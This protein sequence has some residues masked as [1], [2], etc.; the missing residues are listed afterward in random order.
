MK[1]NSPFKRPP[2]PTRPWWGLPFLS[3]MKRDMLGFLQQAHTEYGD[4][5]Y[6]RIAWECNYDFFHPELAREVLVDKASSFIRWERATAIFAQVHGQSVLVTEGDVWQR[7][8]R[9]LQPG[10]GPKR[11]AGYARLMVEASTKAL[12]TLPKEAVQTVDFEHQMTILTMEVIMQTLFSSDAKADALTAEKAVRTIA[13]VGIEEMFVP[14]SLPDWL[15]Q[16]AEFRWAKR[17]L[18]AL[19]WRHIHER[20]AQLQAGAPAKDDLL[21]MLMALR[22]DEANTTGLS[23]TEIRDQCM[24]IF[25]AGHETT[26][27]ALTWWGWTMASNP[28]CAVLATEEVDRVLA[29]RPPV[30]EDVAALAYLGQTLRETMRLHPSVPLLFTRR[31]TEDVQIGPWRVPKGAMVRVTPQVMHHDARWFEDPLAFKPERFTPEAVARQVRGSYM[32]FGTGPRVCIGNIFALT[33]MTLIA[34]MILQRFRLESTQAAAPK[35][36]FAVTLRP[37]NGLLLRLVRRDAAK[38]A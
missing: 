20:R 32:P 10:F 26:A 23:D 3:E 11:M 29:G 37:A 34:A 2:G 8:R 24:T 9:I 6:T 16:K 33:E 36:V 22:D 38:E 31:A 13:R 19:V 35:V 12:D 15:P 18:D 4:A 30:Y 27:T 25:L 1:T 14:F 17:T 28:D 21:G 7:Q 5:V